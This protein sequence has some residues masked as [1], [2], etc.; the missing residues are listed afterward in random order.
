GALMVRYQV[1]HAPQYPRPGETE[2][3]FQGR[4]QRAAGYLARAVAANPDDPEV[5][6]AA[7]ESY[8]QSLRWD[9]A[10]RLLER[11]IAIDPNSPDANT[12]YAYHLGLLG[13]CDEGLKHARIAAG[14]APDVT[15][16]QL[17][18]PRLLHCAG[19]RQAAADIYRDLQ[20]RD[21]ANA[22]LLREVY[23]M[24]LAERNAPALRALAEFTRSDLWRGAP[25]AQIAAQIARM[26]AGADA[27]EGRPQAFLSV[28]EA[29][30]ALYEAAPPDARKFGRTLG[31]AWFVLALEYAQ[32][33][34]SER[35]LEALREAVDRGSLYLPWALPYGATEFPPSVSRTPVYAALWRSSPELVN[36]MNKRAQA[37]RGGPDVTDGMERPADQPEAMKTHV[38]GRGWENFFADRPRQP[39]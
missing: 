7:G 34:A 10:E 19:H 25:P 2:A 6:V 9:D 16:R 35:A 36:L 21:P 13:R 8:R 20:G 11:A 17:A 1:D 3:E 38:R 15:W 28:L 31:D 29:D 5:L 22:F 33:G 26:E 14:L 24:R 4:L 39:E 37:Q 32:A 30:R 18:V 27:L 23:L 12:W